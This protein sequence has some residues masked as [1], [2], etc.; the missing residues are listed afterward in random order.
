MTLNQYAHAIPDNDE[1]AA[2]L[3]GKLFARRQV[4]TPIIEMKTA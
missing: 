1:K 2:Q 4:G 3:V